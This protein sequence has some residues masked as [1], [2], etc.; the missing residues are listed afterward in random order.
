MSK[1]AAKIAFH[2]ETQY[3]KQKLQDKKIAHYNN[4][5]GLC[6]AAISTLIKACINC[7]LQNY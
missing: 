7:K 6:Q 4:L 3:Q 2:L 5:S 1:G